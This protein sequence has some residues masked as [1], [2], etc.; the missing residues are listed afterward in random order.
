MPIFN[1]I[2]GG[3]G[4][5]HKCVTVEASSVFSYGVD[6][7]LANYGVSS[8]AD[9][10]GFTVAYISSRD[11][12]LGRL[13]SIL[14]C[15]CTESYGSATCSYIMVAQSYYVTTGEDSCSVS[16]TN[17][18]TVTIE[19]GSRGQFADGNGDTYWGTF[20]IKS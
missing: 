6:F 14:G 11:S 13:N 8:R 19:S 3:G 2:G 16:V 20:I 18:G 17:S 4:G 5:S 7:N 9:I 10:L 1:M 12:A 15:Y